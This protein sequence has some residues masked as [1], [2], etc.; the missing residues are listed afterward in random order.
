MTLLVRG[1]P[2]LDSSLLALLLAQ[3]QL[4]VALLQHLVEPDE[5]QHQQSAYGPY[6]N[7]PLWQVDVEAFVQGAA[8]VEEE[9]AAV[10]GDGVQHYTGQE[11]EAPVGPRQKSRHKVHNLEPIRTQ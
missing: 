9:G 11:V 3:H 8:A 1:I 7:N 2:R 10:E 6:K 4:S 5:V